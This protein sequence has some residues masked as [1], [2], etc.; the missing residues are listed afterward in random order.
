MKAYVFFFHGFSPGL[1][2]QGSGLMGVW[3][4][5]EFSDLG[6]CCEGSSG[7]AGMGF[8]LWELLSSEDLLGSGLGFLLSATDTIAWEPLA[9]RIGVVFGAPET[10]QRLEDLLGL[11]K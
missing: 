9:F 1:G 3:P 8:W 5:R 10:R 4:V 7:I 11:A 2:L 6:F